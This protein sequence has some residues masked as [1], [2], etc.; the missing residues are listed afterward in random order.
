MFWFRVP[1]PSRNG[2]RSVNTTLIRRAVYDNLPLFSRPLAVLFLLQ[3]YW[4]AQKVQG[5][6][7]SVYPGSQ[8]L[9]LDPASIRQGRIVGML[10]G[11]PPFLICLVEACAMSVPYQLLP[12]MLEF[13]HLPDDYDRR[14]LFAHFSCVSPLRPTMNK[15]RQVR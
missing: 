11:I 6:Q 3:V 15:A 9:A 13:A 10:C 5:Q 4:C 12:S 14:R 2:Y 8:S 7:F 1:Q